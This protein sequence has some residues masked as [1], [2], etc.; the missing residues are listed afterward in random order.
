MLVLLV[1]FMVTAPILQHGVAVDL[2]Q[3][4]A[5]PVDGPDT[6]LVISVSKDGKVHLENR[7][8]SL[9]ELQHR[10]TES[11]QKAP[12]QAVYL[13]ADKG[14]PYG[15]VVEVMAVLRN[16]GVKK[17]SMMTSPIED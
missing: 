10:L 13:R 8:L 6:S 11:V 15:K 2:P 5:G 9:A 14:V 17:L 1:I 12:G 16:V 3:V 7:T 4:A